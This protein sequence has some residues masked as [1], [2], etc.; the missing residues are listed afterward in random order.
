MIYN[1]LIYILVVILIL[2]TGSVPEQPQLA[3]HEALS[4]FLAKGF[5]FFLLTRR[6]FRGKTMDKA[7]HYFSAEQHLSIAAIL[8]FAADVYLLE[9][10]HYL[11]KLPLAAKIPALAHLGGIIL[12][13]SYLALIWL[14]ARPAYGTIFART[15]SNRT[16]LLTNLKINIVIILPWLLLS[17]G[18]DLLRLVPFSG[19]RGLL[20]SPWGEPLLLV[21]FFLV[22][23][24]FF[25]PVI[26]RLWNCTPLPQGPTRQRI[27]TFCRS[28]Q[29]RFADILLWPLF[30]GRMLTAGV[31]G[32]SRR[33]RY[34][35]VTPA[36]LESMAPEEVEAVM[37]HE[38]GHVKRYHLQLY[39]FLF[40][41]FGLLAQLAGLPLLL[42]LLDSDLFHYLVTVTGKPAD[43]VLTFAGTTVLLLV[44]LVYF[45]YVFGFFM[46][47]FE[48]QA[49]I[50]AL[51][52]M[53]TAA[54]LIRVF[55]KIAWLSGKIR[56]LPSWHHFGLG[57]RIRFLLHCEENPGAMARHHRKVFLALGLYSLVLVGGAFVL[58]RLP[59]DFPGEAGAG[60]FVEILLAQ[61]IREEPGN[62][63]WHH[64]LGDL[65]HSRKQY[66]DALASYRQAMVLAP[67]NAETMNNM[68]WLLLT[69]EQT[70]LRDPAL[71]L[72]LARQAAALEKSAHILDTLATA[73]WANNRRPEALAAAGEALRLA[74]DNRDFY[75]RQLERFRATTYS[76]QEP[77]PD[78]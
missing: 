2:S 29:L 35:L 19:L 72:T 24:L 48:R 59:A 70:E 10:L 78:L 77:Y 45:R 74:R 54:P 64:L 4:L 25:P 67:E 43:A 3:W 61:K 18:F 73:Y 60:R 52:A 41:G 40:L 12:F 7:A 34:L 65:H 57:E 32:I 30:E 11:H 31:M 66:G 68:A 23:V 49:D 71:A 20:D 5:F 56:D 6:R 39:L 58:W 63:L 37:A 33:Y 26:V 22:L 27:E 76:L 42:L 46:R 53:G 16:F 75:R 28:Q 17:L 62:P 50:H 15:L 8:F 9:I 55:E 51:T 14:A 36:L 47:N 13:F 1:N 69:A 44:M 21:L 38:I